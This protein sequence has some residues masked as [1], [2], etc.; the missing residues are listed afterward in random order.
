[1][2]VVMVYDKRY[3]CLSVSILK[4]LTRCLESGIRVTKS[5]ME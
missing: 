5:E 2:T 1:M 3:M 4:K